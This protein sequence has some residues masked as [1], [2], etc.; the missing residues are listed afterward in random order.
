MHNSSVPL[1]WR[2]RESK[3]RMMGTKCETCS[4]TFFPP[5]HLC[6]KCRSHGKIEKF[7]FSGCGEIISY[8]II[9]SAPS[10]FENQTP[11]AV[12]I[13]KLKEGPNITGQIVGEIENVDIGKN[14]CSV[15]RKM[16]EDGEEGLNHYGF[17]FKIVGDG[18][19]KN[20]NCENSDSVNDQ[21]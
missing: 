21:V 8:T 11:Y 19:Q 4:T 5:R 14:V 15:F 9:R 1:F 10:G 3:Y 16:Y 20:N 17:K 13:I 12:G 18:T 7:C 2:L 6:P